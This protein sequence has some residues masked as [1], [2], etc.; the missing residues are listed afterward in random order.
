MPSVDDG[1]AQGYAS[2]ELLSKT[3]QLL[4]LPT[5]G[6][7][8]HYITGEFEIVAQRF[9]D[10]SIHKGAAVVMRMK[11]L[12]AYYLA[13]EELSLQWLGQHHL[14]MNAEYLGRLF[15]KETNEK[16]SLYLTRLRIERAKELITTETESRMYEIAERS[17]F[18]GDQQY[19]G[20][21]FK[22]FTGFSPLEYRKSLLGKPH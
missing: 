9:E 20:N 12:I 4:S 6:D 2:E 1:N 8:E 14:F 5:L 13:H 7:V 21:V 10:S 3:A 22:K 16:F 17:G 18:G 15:R 11:R 19:F